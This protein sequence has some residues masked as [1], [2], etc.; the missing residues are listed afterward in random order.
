MTIS[1]AL[2]IATAKA[3]MIGFYYMDL[4]RERTMMY[5][6]LAIGLLSVLILFV[7]IAPDMTFR[8]F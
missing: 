8:R 3:S 2:I 1:I 6:I 4:R 7:G 5:V